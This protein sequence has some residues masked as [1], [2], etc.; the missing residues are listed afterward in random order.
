MKKCWYDEQGRKKVGQTT[1]RVINLRTKKHNHITHHK[2][3]HAKGKN[4]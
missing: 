2:Q 3:Q 4:R 1:R